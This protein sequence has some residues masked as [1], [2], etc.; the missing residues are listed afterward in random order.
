MFGDEGALPVNLGIEDRVVCG[1]AGG[2]WSRSVYG[3]RR[4]GD[5]LPRLAGGSCRGG[6]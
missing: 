4:Y 2:F 3:N 6:R 1:L 5:R